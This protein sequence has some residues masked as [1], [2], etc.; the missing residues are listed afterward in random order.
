MTDKL[1]SSLSTLS[2]IV[3]HNETDIFNKEFYH[4]EVLL[5]QGYRFVSESKPHMFFEAYV[6]FPGNKNQEVEIIDLESYKSRKLN[7]LF[8]DIEIEIKEYKQIH[9]HLFSNLLVDVY[10]ELT[11]IFRKAVK[12]ER[13]KIAQEILKLRDTLKFKYV[14][15]VDYHRFYDI[16]IPNRNLPQGL[17]QPKE[18]L[19]TS[20]FKELYYL[21]VD[22]RII[23]SEIISPEDFTT[24]LTSPVPRTKIQFSVNNYLIVYVLDHL[25]HFFYSFNTS[26]IGNSELFLNKR[27]KTLFPRDLNTARTRG[28]GKKL[29]NKKRF[30]EDFNELKDSYPV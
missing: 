16:Q 2:R 3:F 21:L 10:D 26:V 7:N 28:E 23:D 30:I 5:N 18:G 15:I 29:L 6:K 17:F 25:K 4:D 22:H 13:D 1:K 11:G 24:T 20:F 19:K 8:S 12:D 14:H 27:G 9:E